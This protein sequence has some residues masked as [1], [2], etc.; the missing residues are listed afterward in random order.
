MMVGMHVLRSWLTASALAVALVTPLALAG[1]GASGPK[2]PPVG[3]SEPDK[4]L[5]DHGNEAM[6][7][8]RW[9]AAR[10]YFKALVERYPQSPYRPD[11]KLAL[12]DTYIFENTAESKV[13]AV[14]EFQEFLS[15]FPTSPRADYAQY[16]IGYAHF[17]QMLKPQRDQTETRE[18]LLQFAIF[19]RR[20]P[21]SPLR[22]EVE[23]YNRQA[24]DRLSQSEFEV[25][26]FYAR[27][28]WC[29]G[30][31]ERLQG[32]IKD[33]AAKAAAPKTEA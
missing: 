19:F 13:L 17:K 9:M 12:G 6:A 30:A 18:T 26:R 20:Y 27:L 32:L 28:N 23:K 21:N 7:K 31:V 24:R 16:R 11:A 2:M 3:S 15:F 14:N 1:C 22:P 10:E 5:F 8:K 33:A 29:P 25:G 4:F